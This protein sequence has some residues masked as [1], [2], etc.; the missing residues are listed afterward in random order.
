MK[1]AIVIGAGIGGLATAIRLQAKGYQVEVFEA[2]SYPGGKL[3]QIDAKGYRFDAGPSLFTMPEKIEELLQ[4]GETSIEFNYKKLDEVCRYFYEDETIIKGWGNS[5]KFAD[6]IYSKLKI[7]NNKII[8]HLKKS[9]FIFNAT[10]KLFLEKS[11]HK[12]S[13]YLSF[14]TFKSILKLPFLNINKSMNKVN[15]KALK[16][17]KLVQF[18]NRYGTYN[19]SNPY[20]A[21]G[22]LNIIPHL[23]FGRGAF[24]PENGMYSITKILFKK[25]QM[26]GVKFHFNTKIDKLNIAKNKVESIQSNGKKI[27]STIFIS[28]MDVVPFYKNLMPKEW[29]LEKVM[30]QERSSSALIFYW[31]IKKEFKNLIL[32]NIFFS[33]DYKKE[34]DFIFKKDKV[35]KDPTIYINIS[36]KHNYTDAPNGKENWFVMINVP[37]NKKQ[38]WDA[39]IT[40]SK[41]N[42]ITKLNRVLK[43]NMKDLIEFEEVLDPR[44]IELRTSSYQGSLYGTSSNSKMAAFFRHPNFSKKLSNLYFCGGSVHP[45]GGIPLA[46]SS[47]KIVSDLIP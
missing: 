7:P 37:S 3:T 5:E 39:I 42:I 47:A 11:L 15:E 24:F 40:E 18:F 19:G 34:F 36:S 43:T 35:Y 46:L 20:E 21:P 27:K 41:Q 32:H 6:E 25:A 45:G 13:T 31:G 38:D 9:K 22:I 12:I 26:L 17:P 4:L 10:N 33:D 28:N 30:K 44:L 16:H 1:K 14:N 2:N 23:E 8:K 29:Q